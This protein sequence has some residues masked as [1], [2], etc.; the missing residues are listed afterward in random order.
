MVRITGD[1]ISSAQWAIQ[2]ADDGLTWR[3]ASIAIKECLGVDEWILHEDNDHL[4]WIADSLTVSAEYRQT[5]PFP[6]FRIT[7]EVL[8]DFKDD[9]DGWFL[10]SNLNHKA[11]GGAYIYRA[12]TKS[13]D[14]VLYCAEATWPDFA[15]LLL[16]TKTAIGQCENL[17]RREDTLRFANCRSA[18]RP[19]PLHGQR[20]EH[21]E[22]FLE[23]F[24]D[25]TQID[26]IGGLWLSNRERD[27]VFERISE[28]CS[29]VEIQPGW[30]E[31]VIART[32]ESMDFGFQISIDPAHR[33]VV[34]DYTA[35][36][37]IEFNCWT[38]FGRSIVAHVSLPLF[39]WGG[40]FDDGASHDEAVRLASLLNLGA[41][42]MC[43]QKLG[44]GAWFAKGSQICFSMA[45]PH[46]NLK[47]VVMG[48]PRYEVADVVFDVVNPNMVH[49]LVNVAVRE[50]H[51]I[52]VL[53]QRDPQE[54]DSIVSVAQLRHD[55]SP[56]RARNESVQ[57]RDVPDSLWDLPSTP[58]LVYGV[59]NPVG[60]SLGSVELIHG[61]ESGIIV[62]R[63][64][65]HMNPGEEVLSVLPE[66][67][68]ELTSTVRQSV[69]RLYE[70]TFIPDF[71][72]IQ[73]DL[74]PE[75]KEAVF[76][77]LVDMC[78]GFSDEQVD[79]TLK[80][81]QIQH[82]PN[83]WWRPIDPDS[84]EMPGI[85]EFEELTP[86]EAYLSTVLKPELVDYN[87]GLFQAWWEGAL[88]FLKD[89]DSPGEATKTVE[90][91]TQH[92]L[93]RIRGQRA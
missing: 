79:L 37:L 82:Q 44:L 57:T 51:Q 40:I 86:S 87:L 54:M 15:L 8:A 24:W 89:P 55:K 71:I 64:R 39:T 70:Y 35:F 53:S 5:S 34:R 77:G 80:A 83:P 90:R 27:G 11:V 1:P 6:Q 66:G 45:I 25:V 28:E 3:R 26:F 73:G 72:Q 7:I 41:S 65:H 46:A 68:T 32:I 17:S 33:S 23:R 9:N 48:A 60:P 43:W 75:T 52:N 21:H 38:D 36:S 59:F 85:P 18:A 58:L 20:S 47:P 19:H 67:T 84:E 13:L 14:F 93:D 31:S 81:M 88:A 78:Q 2:E 62:N 49:R 16:G 92:T 61:R 50:L 29:W 76:D 63:Y 12:Q 69:G 74:A 4:V 91:F 22:L 56:V 30:S 42:E 10:A